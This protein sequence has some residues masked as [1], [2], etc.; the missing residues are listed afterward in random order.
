MGKKMKS[1]IMLLITAVIWGSAFVAQ[2][3]GTVLEPFTYNGIR[4]FIG[5]LVL[6]PVILIFGKLGL[7]D[8][9]VDEKGNKVFLNKVTIVGG[10]CCGIVL[11]VASNLQ[12]FGMYFDTDAGKAGFITSLYI[13]LVPILGMFL[14][15]KV[16]PIVW[17]C[18]A[19]GVAGFYMLTMAGKGTEIGT[20][21]EEIK[22]IIDGIHYN[23]HVMVCLDTCHIHDAG[24]DLNNFDKVLEEFDEVIGLDYLKCVHIND[25]KNEIE[26]HKDRHENIGYGCIGFDNLI[27]V[28]Y[29]KKLDNIPKILETP[30]IEKEYPPYKQEIEM[31]KNKKFNPNLNVDVI[32]Y[33][34]SN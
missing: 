12:Q 32:E 16:K 17:G 34:S 11:C 6:I 1:N 9:T 25:S 21:F 8:D 5:G 4:M 3:A 20:T 14:G 30:Y 19:L 29:H 18:V 24:Y 10:I 23:E 27:K 31:I 2:K 22:Q 26:S 28:I 33:Y 15:K 13:V 7:S